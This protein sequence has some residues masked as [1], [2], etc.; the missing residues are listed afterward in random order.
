[1]QFLQTLVDEQDRRIARA[2]ERY[3]QGNQEEAKLP[4]DVQAEFETLKEQIKE[5]QTQSEVMGEQG[6]VDASMQAFNKANSLQLHLQGIEARALKADSKRQYVDAISGL[7]YSSTDNEARIADLQSGRQYKGWKAIREKLIE[8]KERN[9]PR[10]GDGRGSVPRNSRSGR[11]D[12]EAERDRWDEVDRTRKGRDD[13]RRDDG[14]RDRRDYTRGDYDR[15]DRDAYAK[16]D[17]DRRDFDRRGYDRR[18]YDRRD[19]DRRSF[20]RRCE[21]Y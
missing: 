3:E 16:H 18:D 6:D 19:Y 11:S 10:S 14:R 15:R 1:M 9:P 17:Y 7:V 20:D 5:L 8:L 12:R 21:R 13:E 4:P 2:K